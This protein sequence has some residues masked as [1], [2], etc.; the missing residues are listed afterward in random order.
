MTRTEK[1]AQE[2]Q[3]IYESKK[4]IIEDLDRQTPLGGSNAKNI[5]G[6]DNP[7]NG[8]IT[9]AANMTDMP[10]LPY[11]SGSNPTPASAIPKCVLA[12][13]EQAYDAIFKSNE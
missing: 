11:W 13:V 2:I 6:W 10:V 3:K 1:L 7:H 9:R 12:S 8:T 4:A 5:I